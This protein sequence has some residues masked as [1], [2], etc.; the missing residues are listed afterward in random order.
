MS[1]HNMKPAIY[2]VQA[3]GS[4]S[5]TIMA[6]PESGD[7]MEQEFSGI[8]SA[9]INKIVC[10]L[11]SHE[12]IA[13]GLEKEKI[14]TERHGMEY[15]SYPIVDRGLPLVVNE[16]AEFTKRLHNEMSGGL[17][18][19]VHCHGGIGRSGIVATAILLHCGFTAEDAFDHVTQ[20]R[21]VSVPDTQEQIDWIVKNSTEI[22]S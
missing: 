9:G 15:L 1:M 16:F 13:L 2:N 19:L 21:G 6:K 7:L 17:N 18:T 11:E 5:L 3:I 12:S 20:Q 8:A 14:M 4:G 10:L 22:V